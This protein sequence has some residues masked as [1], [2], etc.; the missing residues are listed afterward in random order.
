MATISSLRKVLVMI[1]RKGKKHL[2][3]KQNS[4][5]SFYGTLI[6]K[7]SQNAYKL[8]FKPYTKTADAW[9]HTEAEM[10]VGKL[11]SALK[12]VWSA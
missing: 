10:S 1:P 2:N 6:L 11:S 12:G 5:I 8:L 3:N 4:N 9:L 7:E